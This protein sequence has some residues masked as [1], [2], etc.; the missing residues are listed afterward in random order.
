MITTE[1]QYK[2]AMRQMIRRVQRG[3]VVNAECRTRE[4]A[5]VLTDCIKCEY[6]IGNTKEP[7]RT[8]DGKAHPEIESDVIPLKGIIFLENKPDWEFL[9]PTIISVIALLVSIFR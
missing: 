1:W 3:E 6:I 8:L 2:E 4:E 7:F 9:V 5:E